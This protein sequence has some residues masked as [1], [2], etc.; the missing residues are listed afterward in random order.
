VD[1]SKKWRRALFIGPKITA[2]SM[3]AGWRLIALAAACLAVLAVAACTGNPG[4]G[5]AS[6]PSPGTGT[7]ST[8]IASSSPGTAPES[9]SASPTLVSIPAGVNAA[10]DAR[11][12]EVATAWARS[13]F[14]KVW[15][16][17]L[18]LFPNQILTVPVIQAALAPGS[19]A[20]VPS[21]SLIPQ[22]VPA[23]LV[24]VAGAR[25]LPGGLALEVA[26]PSSPCDA[27][28]GPLE[29]AAASAVV[30]GAWNY[31]PNPDAPCPSSLLVGV[32][33]IRLNAPLAGRVI[34]DVVGGEPVGPGLILR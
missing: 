17:G 21:A 9:P 8:G 23:D 2:R 19:Y 11:A 1:N 6:T 12:R 30:V 32:R 33:T 16:T 34:L 26:V 10:F 24:G 28:S 29:Y 3:H 4:A 20:T 25:A 13:P 31:N 22:P 18:V 7:A 14:A 5:S 27:G 15:P